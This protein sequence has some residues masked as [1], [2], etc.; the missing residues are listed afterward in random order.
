MV[1]LKTFD[2]AS[3][4]AMQ[5]RGHARRIG[6]RKVGTRLERYSTFHLN[7]SPDMKKEHAVGKMI[8]QPPVTLLPLQ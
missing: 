5:T 4:M 6:A 7:L 3:R 2:G 1:K 8:T